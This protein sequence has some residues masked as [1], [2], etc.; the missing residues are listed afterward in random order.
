MND[1]TKYLI[2]ADV[3]VDGVVERNDVVGAIFGQTEGLLGT[4]LDLRQL[5]DSSKVG[6]IDVEIDSREGRS[7][8]D[9][10]IAT[11]LDRVETATLA[12]GLET[13]T[14]IGPC[15]ATIEIRDIEDIR[16]AKRREVVERA[17]ELL[18]EAF[19]G[20]VATSDALLSE[21][22]REVRVEDITEYE[23]L[24]A[25]P[26]VPDSDATVVVEGRADVLALLRYGVKN[27]IA[28]EG[29]GV[30]EAVAR[31]SEG[32]TTT[33]FVD[34]DRGG[35]LI[36]RELGQMG[37]VDYVAFSPGQSVEDLSRA[38]VFQALRDKV[39]FETAIGRLDH[40][41]AGTDA[42]TTDGGTAA[43]GSDDPD[44]PDI[45]DSPDGPDVT[46]IARRVAAELDGRGT[47]DVTAASTP[48][49][50]DDAATAESTDA[51]T[52]TESPGD[53]R[54][55]ADVSAGAVDDGTESTDGGAGGGDLTRDAETETGQP[56][57][58]TLAEHVEAVIHGETGLARL[59]DD[60]MG[61]VDEADADDAFS[62][63]ESTDGTA[64]ALVLDGELDQR[65]LDV[66]A[67]RGL[68]QALVRSRGSYVKR[69]TDVRIRTAS[70]LSGEGVEADA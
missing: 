18:A 47:D 64:A 53:T 56:T 68:G 57:P 24:P 17:K 44:A 3:T 43:D 30:P 59:V 49:S 4:E 54:T 36:L 50:T 61:V 37:D 10:T 5:Q 70:E 6:R 35:R 2:H 16:E 42:A 26:H 15:R 28:V 38:E 19:D 20:S 8:G 58:G 63:V 65:T 13:I 7:Y 27:A 69:P 62:L 34:D 1:T 11:S 31:L 33:A 46:E 39:P 60:A 32:R 52:A 67:Q 48:A 25:G 29:T 55:N 12:A 40:R 41:E 45:P 23:G 9:L 14:R 22:R 66:L 21:V 51:D